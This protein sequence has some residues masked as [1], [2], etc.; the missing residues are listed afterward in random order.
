M[1][2]INSLILLI[3]SFS[4]Q[5]LLADK[6][7]LS[8]VHPG[9]TAPRAFAD[10][11]LEWN[12]TTITGSEVILGVTYANGYFWFTAGGLVDSSEP[13]NYLYQVS[14][15]GTLVNTFIQNTTSEWGWRDLTTDG[16]YLYGSDSTVI[17]QI[18]MVTGQSTGVTIPV[19]GG[20]TVGRGLAYDSA[21]DHFFV[22]GFGT[23]I[24]EIDRTGAVINTITSTHATYG[25][26]FERNI[27]GGPYVYSWHQDDDADMNR[28][29][30]VSGVDSGVLFG[31]QPGRF[32]GG[33]ETTFLLN[34]GQLQM[35][36]VEQGSG[37]S[38][39]DFLVVY[40]MDQLVILIPTLSQKMT[41]VFLILLMSAGLY[42]TYRRRRQAASA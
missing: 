9:A 30:T 16:T 2:R 27:F 22:A 3:L 12:V 21:T 23:N 33:A 20:L 28:F 8:P 26:A 19:P 25:L 5:P 42:W 15:A 34:P 4:F 14:T 32:A 41:I 7:E 11:L 39:A 24:F 40:D 36:A 17:D 35:L 38:S 10:I 31:A 18:S 6:N 29:Q 1:K 37:V 13:N